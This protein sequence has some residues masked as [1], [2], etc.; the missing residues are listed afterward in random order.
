MESFVFAVLACFVLL[1]IASFS[2]KISEKWK[3]PHSVFLVMIG[4]VL[5]LLMKLFPPL[6]FLGEFRLSPE[7]I[8][9]VFLPT[10]IF[11]S[12]FNTPLRKI[13]SDSIPIGLLAIGGYIISV[14]SITGILYFILN[15]LGFHFPLL[16][17]LLFAVII[18]ATDPVAVLSVFKKLG[19]TPRLTR[20]FEGESL[21]NDGTSLAAFLILTSFITV[22]SADFSFF[23]PLLALSQF[24]VMIIG[25]IVFGVGMGYLFSVLIE[26]VKGEETIQLTLTLIMAHMTFLLADLSKHILHF[27]E[28]HFEVSSIIATVMASMV[29]GS[30]GIQKFSPEVR[31]HM[32]VLWEHFAFIANSLIFILIG[33]MAVDV[34]HFNNIKALGIPIVMGIIVTVI[35]RWISV[36]FPITAYNQ[37]ATPSQKI[38]KKW[39]AILSWASLRGAIAIAAL[40]L[41]P[42]D[43]TLANWPLQHISVKDFVTTLVISCILFTT[44]V[45]AMSLEYFVDQMDLAKFSEVENI[46]V[47]E[48]KILTITEVLKRLDHLG[49]K[50]YISKKNLKRIEKKYK[51]LKKASIRRLSNIFSRHLNDKEVEDFLHLHTLSIEG[52]MLQILIDSQE[53][54]EE[55]YWRL[56]GKVIR[57]EDRIKTGQEQ[58]QGKMVAEKDIDHKDISCRYQI[59]RARLIVISKVIKRLHELQ[60]S[61]LCI[62]INPLEKV[63]NQYKQWEIHADE[64]RKYIEDKY[65]AISKRVEYA[66]FSQYSKQVELDIMKRLNDKSILDGRVFAQLKKSGINAS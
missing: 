16:A 63:I 61:G 56:K 27:G 19:V 14:V 33:M 31:N 17:I 15:I 25:G 53:I 44:F 35:G 45:K 65:P 30:K 7:L 42:P 10:L 39:I 20:I 62:P 46:E 13:M 51:C 5:V 12:S 11:E 32:N 41:I 8:F 48:G 24:I 36:Y 18:S 60:S 40:L 37:F 22:H 28:Y 55:V 58:I 1:L 59:A 66:I 23:N 9:F 6:Q 2:L 49:K 64:T 34:L 52:K 47:L 43:M 38:P 50:D 26:W 29:L 57:Q 54:T 21:F 4:I 3:V